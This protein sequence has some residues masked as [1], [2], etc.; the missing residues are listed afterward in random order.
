MEND[1]TAKQESVE[2]IGHSN[3]TRSVSEKLERLVEQLQSEFPTAVS[4]SFEFKRDLNLYVDFRTFEEASLAE[5]RLPALCGGIF[6]NI[7]PGSS[8]THSYLHRIRAKVDT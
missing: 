5:A 7:I 3:R 1:S 8:P 4:I 2:D 6:S